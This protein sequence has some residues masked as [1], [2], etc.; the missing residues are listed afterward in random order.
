MGIGV[1]L[2]QAPD[3]ESSVLLEVADKTLD[4]FVRAKL[5]GYETEDPPDDAVDDV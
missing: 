2:F 3:Y 5:A 4:G 1:R